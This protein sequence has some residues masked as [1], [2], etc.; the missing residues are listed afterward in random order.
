MSYILDALKKADTERERSAVPGLHAHPQ[1]GWAQAASSPRRLPWPAVAVGMLVLAVAALAWMLWSD[2]G[3]RT[4]PLVAAA[5]EPAAPTQGLPTAP[6]PDRPPVMAT[7]APALVAT[8]APAPAVEAS[9]PPRPPLAPAPAATPTPA[10]PAVVARAAPPPAPS[11]PPPP[12]RPAPK[13]EPRVP[14]LAELPANVRAGLPPLAISGAVYSPTPSA[15]MLFIGT[16]MVREGE[17]V[18][19]GVTVERIGPTSSVLSARGVRFEI[20]H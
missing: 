17:A 12:P 6:P 15:R 8:P 18:A 16:Q 7:P 10:A 19:D 9:P 2:R 4:P 13:P 1:D 3:V 20:R 14:S 5:P 11:P